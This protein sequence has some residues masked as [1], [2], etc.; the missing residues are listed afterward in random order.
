MAKKEA[1]VDVP[2]SLGDLAPKVK[3]AAKASRQSVNDYIV[4]ALQS[5]VRIEQEYAPKNYTPHGGQ[6]K[7]GKHTG[8]EVTKDGKYYPSPGSRAHFEQ[9]FAERGAIYDLM[10]AVYNHAQER[11]M[12]VEKN[13]QRAKEN[14]IDDW[15]LD[16]TKNWAYY[17]G[18]DAHMEEVK[19]QEEKQE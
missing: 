4:D 14:L 10:N 13:L 7:A 3:A 9:L 12:A 5:R 19:K 11:L 1:T 16:P 8:Y 2:L 15:G 6:H 18:P 17:G